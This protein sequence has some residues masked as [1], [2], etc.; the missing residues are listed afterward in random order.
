MGRAKAI[1][2]ALAILAPMAPAQDAKDKK[3]KPP[4]NVDQNDVRLGW[5]GCYRPGQWAPLYV[6]VHNNLKKPFDGLLTFQAQQDEL[7]SM[8]IHQRIALTPDMPR[9]VPMAVKLAVGAGEFGLEIREANGRFRWGRTFSLAG[10]G[11]YSIP[12]EPIAPQAVLIGV[13]GSPGFGLTALRG[14]AHAAGAA[15]MSPDR[16]RFRDGGR[17]S[18]RSG[19]VHVKT[20]PTKE[21]PWDWTGYAC[22]DVLV[23]YGADWDKFRPEQCRAI[24]E[25]VGNGGSVLIVPGGRS[26]SAEEELAKL[27]PFELG[28]A[29]EVAVPS[30]VIGRWGV[31]GPGGGGAMPFRAIPSD[32]GGGWKVTRLQ[33]LEGFSGT[34]GDVPFCAEGPYGF[35]RVGVLACELA[36]LGDR[37]GK[38]VAPF[39]I[40]RL[41]P[42]L[43]RRELARGPL[44]EDAG[45]DNMGMPPY[46]VPNAGGYYPGPMGYPGYYVS[47]ADADTNAVLDH[48][49]DIPELRPL[50]IWVVIGLLTGLALLIGPVDYLVLKRLGR[51][52]LTWVTSAGCVVIFTVGA[53]YGVKALR[54][55]RV[56]VRVV[57]VVDGIRNPS[58]EGASTVWATTYSGIFAPAHDDYPLDRL[59]DRQW[60]SSVVPT[61][62]EGLNLFRKLDATRRIT[63]QQRDGCNLPVSVPISEWTM[64]NLI[65][66]EPL[67]AMPF[68]VRMTRGDNGEVE[69]TVINTCDDP[70]RGGWLRVGGDKVMRLGPVEANSFR[71]FSGGLIAG[72]K[73]RR[74]GEGYAP[75]AFNGEPAYYGAGTLQRTLAI[76]EC[77]RRGGAVVCL[78]YDRSPPPFHLKGRQLDLYHLRM[79][80]L[81]VPGEED[82]QR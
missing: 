22:L 62:N 80:R 73:W 11:Q 70:V 25:Y 65:T 13:V 50:S 37:Q 20:C 21:L 53:Y 4:F 5:G 77:L 18:D 19:L 1:I 63:C 60:W 61:S 79:A 45:G 41:N 43:L 78:E 76:E 8:E 55:S 35:G 39:W 47:D 14:G 23:L 66:E 51:L 33:D 75:G 48:L 57:S 24:L 30:G 72:Q 16:A 10:Y 49:L 54:G 58:G 26:L 67:S 59:A 46:A 27:L 29:R 12:A 31:S 64:Q 17:A 36:G 44:S 28:P 7:T 6:Q 9:P 40:D 56:Q 82:R 3:D 71:K 42:L 38:N 52:P 34:G 2:L 68:D 32:P 81:L 15:A 74:G 69:L